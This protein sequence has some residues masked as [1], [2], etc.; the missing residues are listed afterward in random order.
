[1]ARAAI[2]A[3][4]LT[5]GQR[6]QLCA[7]WQSHVGDYF[8]R[9]ADLHDDHVFRNSILRNSDDASSS[10]THTVALSRSHVLRPT[11]RRSSK[12]HETGGAVERRALLLSRSELRCACQRVF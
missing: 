3:D 9:I 2:A 6:W 7:S 10:R 4:G 1:M 12:S 8:E 5:H 11:T